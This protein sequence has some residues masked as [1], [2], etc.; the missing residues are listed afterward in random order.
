LNK[1]KRLKEN[2][3]R[4]LEL[5]H[6]SFDCIKAEFHLRFLSVMKY[7]RKQDKSCLVFTK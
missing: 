4:V 2:V 5:I 6:S 1:L 7:S 3:V